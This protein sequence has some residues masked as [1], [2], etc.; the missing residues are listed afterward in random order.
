M[1]MAALTV[2]NRWGRL[3][4]LAVSFFAIA[5]FAHAP[6]GPALADGGGGDEIEVSLDQARLV[7]LPER[8]STLVI[9]NPLIADASNPANGLMVVTGK[10]YG[11]TNIIALDRAGVTLME[12]QVVVRGADLGTIVVYRGVQRE[13]Y[14]CS[15]LCQPRVTLGDAPQFF[16]T[17]LGQTGAWLGAVNAAA[18]LGK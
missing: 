12:K 11:V 8:A 15:P 13:T 1:K 9:G 14:S 16:S 5:A 10:G 17:N 2:R 4:R 3:L 7:K 6:F 18:Q